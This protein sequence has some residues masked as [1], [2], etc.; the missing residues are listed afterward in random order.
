MIYDRVKEQL[1]QREG[2][3]APCFA[4]SIHKCGSSLMHGMIAGV[5]RQANIAGVTLPDIL[6]DLGIADRE[7]NSEL[8][9]LPAFQRNLLYF[10]FRHLPEIFLNPAFRL[11]DRRFVLLVRDPRDALV[12]QYFSFGRKAASHAL[13]KV[14][15]D[16]VGK[17]IEMQPDLSIDDYVLKFAAD[18]NRKLI[19][20]RSALNFELGLV[21]RYEQIFFDKEMFLSEIF[22]HFKIDVPQNIISE[23]ARANDIRPDKEDETKH[24]RKGTPGDHAEKLQPATIAKLNDVFRDVG[25]FY[26]Y[27]L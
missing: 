7:W 16:A 25:Y 27:A 20:Y 13:P 14:N 23:V 18:L 3:F 19:S 24:I 26:G 10:G 15:P 11:R 1:P 17:I 12:S 4:F 9:L 6:F 2:S 22:H 8:T 5:C 21:R